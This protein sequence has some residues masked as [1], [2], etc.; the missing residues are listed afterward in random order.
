M[1]QVFI[2]RIIP[3]LVT[4]AAGAGYFYL[5]YPPINPRASGFWGMLLFMALVFIVSFCFARIRGG[6]AKIKESGKKVTVTVKKPRKSLSKKTVRI[7]LIVIGIAAVALTA[8]LMSSTRLVSASRYQMQL[9][10]TD[11]NFALDIA[12]VPISQVPVVDRDTAERLGQ[13]KIGEVVELV[14]QFNVSSFFTQINVEEVPTRVSPL[15][16]ADFF[17][18]FGNQ[19]DGI[20]YYVK[21]DMA[22]QT[23]EL[24]ELSQ[25]IKY[26][27]S[28]YF[29]RKL[30][31]YLRFKYPTLMFEEFSFEIDDEGNPFW[32]VSC[33][34]YTIGLLG[35]KDITAVLLVNAVTGEVGKYDIGEVPQWIDRVFPAELIV[36]QADNWGSLGGGYWNSVFGQKGVTVTTEGYNYLA[37]NDD[38]WMYTG[39]TSVSQDESNIGFLLVNMRTKE[40]KFYQVNGA[41]EYSAMDSARGKVQ[42]KGYSATFPILLNIGDMPTY[43]LS[44]K[45]DAG[46]VKAFAFVSVS[47]YQ[48]VGVGDTI[49]LAQQDYLRQLRSADLTGGEDTQETAEKTGRVESLGSA[50]LDGNTHYYIKLEGGEDVYIAPVSVSDYLPLL[51]AGDRVRLTYSKIA[52]E[53][54]RVEDMEVISN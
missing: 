36:K 45:D 25:G 50:V 29:N 5:F 20:P 1:K 21:I 15:E 49:A 17:K 10:V 40:A 2:K 8:A 54:G 18:W 43:F 3:P 14:S 30:E 48:I 47:N 11:G 33:Y 9:P 53:F 46:L 27:P 16:Y 24:V 19:S 51:K 32:V 39:V 44:L 13:R 38:V 35:G 12:E 7:T 22:T 41:K 42:E 31:R 23:T 37:L 34:S 52:G 26:S 4:L 28:E 6:L